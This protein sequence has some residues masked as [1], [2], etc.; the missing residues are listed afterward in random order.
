MS[1]FDKHQ[2]VLR[3]QQLPLVVVL[4][5]RVMQQ[6]APP[7][8][9]AVEYGGHMFS[10]EA[11]SQHNAPSTQDATHGKSSQWKERLGS[12]NGSGS[13]VRN[14]TRARQTRNYRL[15]SSSI[16]PKSISRLRF[17]RPEPDF[18]QACQQPLGESDLVYFGKPL[19]QMLV[20]FA[21]FHHKLL[22]WTYVI[23]CAQRR[24]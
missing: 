5:E 1:D 3:Q 16:R 7:A 9:V 19:K 13:H 18:V 2:L 14:L 20:G 15:A 8:P 21:P 11:C 6:L 24:R 23:Q 22:A 10:L 4:L 17:Q 12:G